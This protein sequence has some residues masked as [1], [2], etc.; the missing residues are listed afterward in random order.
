MLLSSFTF[1]VWNLALDGRYYFLTRFLFP[2]TQEREAVNSAD[3]WISATIQSLQKASPT[4][5]KIS[6]RSV[7][8]YDAFVNTSFSLMGIDYFSTKGY[9]WFPENTKERKKMRRKMIF[10]CLVVL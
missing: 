10:L 1:S 3:N 4:S 7:W 5:L 8:M 6:L 9:V 2:L